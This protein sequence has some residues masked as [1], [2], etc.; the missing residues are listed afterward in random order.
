MYGP[1]RSQYSAPDS[2]ESQNKK[3][4]IK[5]L[6]LSQIININQKLIS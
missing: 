4:E 2:K 5:S 3:Q 1:V 6:T